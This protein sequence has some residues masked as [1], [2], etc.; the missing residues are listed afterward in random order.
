MEAG[1]KQH[2]QLTAWW[3]VPLCVS[4]KNPA[5]ILTLPLVS[6]NYYLG[7]PVEMIQQDG[8]MAT[9]LQVNI[10]VDTREISQLT[11]K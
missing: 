7:L 3:N 9:I 4:T 11:A 8:P 5:Q 1:D 2:E 6:V 10:N